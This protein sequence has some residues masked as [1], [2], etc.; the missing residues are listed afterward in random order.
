VANFLRTVLVQN[1]PEAADRVFQEQLPVNP[2]T[3]ILV[4][5]RGVIT[6]AD[7]NNPIGDLLGTITSLGV[8]FRGQDIIRGRLQ[9]LAVLNALVCG[10]PPWGLHPASAAGN[11]WHICVPICF[12]RRPYMT[13]ECFPAVRRGDLVLDVTVDTLVTNVDLIDLQIE[14]VELLDETPDRYLKYTLNSVTF[15]GTGDQ[16]VR[17]PIGNPLLGVLLHGTTSPAGANQT[18]TWER[19][20]LRVDNVEALYARANWASMQGEMGRRLTVPFDFLQDHSHRFNGAAAGFASTLEQARPGGVLTEY[21][22][23]DFDP[24]QDGSYML[25]TAGRAD[26]VIHRDA[27]TA[28]LGRF[29]PVELVEVRGHAP[30]AAAT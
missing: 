25:E 10:S 12:G 24:L 6:A 28:D 27:G 14:T 9:D 7:T 3:Q 18:A 13:Q 1:R 30:G 5:L 8:S 19:L 17:L 22:Y 20:R 2:L 4:T 26:V 16:D 23:M 21:A 29:V 11:T 15:S